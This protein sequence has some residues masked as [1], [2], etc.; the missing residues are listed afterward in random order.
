MSIL[1]LGTT[2]LASTVIAFGG[3]RDSARPAGA[4]ARG[5]GG[6]S[7]FAKERV[8]GTCA[9]LKPPPAKE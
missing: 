1:V 6:V 7:D 5:D 3:Q 8:T 9:T 2:L 4:P